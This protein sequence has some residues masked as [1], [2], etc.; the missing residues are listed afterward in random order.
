VLPRSE[1]LPKYKE[2]RLRKKP[3][4][5]TQTLRPGVSGKCCN[6]PVKKPRPIE[7]KNTKTNHISPGHR[8]A[9]LCSV[10]DIGTHEKEQHAQRR[11]DQGALFAE[12]A[13]VDSAG[14]KAD[15]GIFAQNR[16]VLDLKLHGG[17]RW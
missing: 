10:L 6:P 17:F 7:A 14:D 1:A 9:T 15:S 4:G 5:T 13:V 16:Q 2:I 11:G 12:H 8:S 3:T